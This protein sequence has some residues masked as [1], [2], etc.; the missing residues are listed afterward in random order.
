[1][2]RKLW[3]AAALVLCGSV[4][5]VVAWAVLPRSP[6]G[7][8]DRAAAALAKLGAVVIRD[9]DRPGKPVVG[10]RLPP[11]ATDEQLKELAPL[12]NLTTLDLEGTQ[13]TEMGLKEL[14][15]LT[16]LTTLSP[17]GPLTD[18]VLRSLREI[19]LLHA[20]TQASAEG[21]HRPDRPEH[22]VKLD[23]SGTK[24]T[25]AGLAELAPLKNLNTLLLPNPSEW[26]GE[27]NRKSIRMTDSEL[28]PL[29]EIGLLHALPVAVAAWGKRPARPEYVLSLE[30][31]GKGV[32][33]EGLKGLAKFKNL[34]TLD[35][36]D[37]AVTD[38][39]LP[40]MIQLSGLTSLDL[41]DTG[42]TVAGLHDLGKLTN[43]T[44]LDLRGIAVTDAG[45]KE[46]APLKNLHTLGLDNN[47]LTDSV[48]RSL[49]EMGLLHALTQASAAPAPVYD[50]FGRTIQKG[51][52]P[53]RSEDVVELNLWGAPVTGAGLKEVATL[54]NLKSLLL[55][56]TKVTDAGLRELAPLKDLATL[57]LGGTKVTD[58]GLKELAPLQKLTTLSLPGTLTDGA[59]RSLHEIGLLHALK[60]PNTWGERPTKPEDVVS[61]DLSNTK[62]TDAGLKELAPLK[63]L[64]TLKLNNDQVA[65]VALHSLREIGL[66]HALEQ[67]KA[68][69]SSDEPWLYRRPTRPEEVDS[70]DLSSTK[71][72]DAGLKELAPLTNL[73]TLDLRRTKVTGAGLK[74]LAPL[75]NLKHLSLDNSD[76]TDGVLQSLREIGLLHALNG[77]SGPTDEDLV[78]LDLSETAVTDEGLKELLPLKKLNTLYLPGG[79]Y[80]STVTDK[81]LAVLAKLTNLTTLSLAG[82]QVTDAGLKELAKLTNLTTLILPASQEKVTSA[83]EAELQK[84]LPNCKIKR[85]Y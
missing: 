69:P 5:A 11:S 80:H 16:N 10:V 64:T 49:R 59:L 38:A 44:T 67:A 30:L 74:E 14:A 46:L 31:H 27:G 13:V 50:D 18:G 35:L 40:E 33:D 56:Q 42:V 66:L 9:Y 68:K 24:V 25:D 79:Q 37:T 20:L 3:F 63:K 62:V 48:L 82:T 12:K 75:K 54:K 22:V 55:G 45:L 70:L 34:T 7:P 17:P 8:E 61:L 6:A 19:G 53:T 36:G 28:C 57:D 71:V 77:A 23:L 26:Y 78:K 76:I 84:M 51:K 73:S 29:R 60:L 21:G 2:T 15:P 52:R 32:T 72:T 85:G 58:D 83:G 41:H 47:Q 65:D 81:G 43:L 1:M 4:L 39:S